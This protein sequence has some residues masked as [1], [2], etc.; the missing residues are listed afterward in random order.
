MSRM[1]KC[2]Q[3]YIA[4]VF[5]TEFMEATDA[6]A[7]SDTFGTTIREETERLWRGGF[8]SK[9]ELQD[10]Y[11]HASIIEIHFGLILFK[12]GASTETPKAKLV[13]AI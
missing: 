4:G 13:A 3:T 1:P 11:P 12:L 10:L 7:A 9:L 6:R 5:L 2:T 8:F